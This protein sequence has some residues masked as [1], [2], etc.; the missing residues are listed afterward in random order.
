MNGSSGISTWSHCV[1]TM[2]PAGRTLLPP[3]DESRTLQGSDLGG[4]AMSGSLLTFFLA[5]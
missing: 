4:V 3:T 1:P 2:A 5:R